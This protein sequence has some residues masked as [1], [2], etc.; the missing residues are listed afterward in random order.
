MEKKKI[1]SGKANATRSNDHNA[2]EVMKPFLNF[3]VK[4]IT[5][6]GSALITIVRNIPKPEGHTAKP[7]KDGRIIKI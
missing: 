1:G 5:V 4:A 7:K 6:I 3:G 2:L